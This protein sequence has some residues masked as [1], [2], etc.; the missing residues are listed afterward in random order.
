MNYNKYLINI[1]IHIDIWY[2]TPKGVTTYLWSK[3]IEN[4]KQGSNC[5]V[6]WLMPIFST[7]GL[8]QEGHK[9]ETSLD[10]LFR[11][12]FKRAIK[13]QANPSQSKRKLERT[14]TKGVSKSHVCLEIAVLGMEEGGTSVIGSISGTIVRDPCMS[15][16]VCTCMVRDWDPELTE[17]QSWAE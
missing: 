2:A 4:F 8:R 1:Y 10:Y 6:W 16:W 7:L 9:F 13:K 5:L 3:T 15:A 17:A 11:P 14:K 12:H